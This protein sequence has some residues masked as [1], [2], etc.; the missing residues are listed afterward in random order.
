MSYHLSKR[1]KTLL[2]VLL[3]LVIIVV[4]WFFV[5]EPTLTKHNK[6][7]TK[8]EEKEIQLHSLQS[9]YDDYKNA[10][11]KALDETAKFN[12]YKERFYPFM[13]GEDIDNLL[14]R[15]C[16]LHNLKPYSL[17]INDITQA[18][19]VS[20]ADRLKETEDDKKKGS[21]IISKTDVTMSVAGDILNAFA[22]ADEI[23][24]NTSIRLKEYTYNK[25]ETIMDSTMILTFELYMLSE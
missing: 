9:T 17:T 16:L 19:V 25:G 21:S 7:Q 4:G 8:L 13:N 10:P 1:E 23:K 20:F 14:T 18:D 22:L 2:Y 5:L 15:M 24:D 6:L 3:L 12:T 11:E